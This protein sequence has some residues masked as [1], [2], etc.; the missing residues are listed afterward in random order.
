MEICEIQTRIYECLERN[1]IVVLEDGMLDEFDSVMFITTVVDIESIFSISIPDEYLRIEE[2][3]FLKDIVQI[4]D[5][6]LHNN[7]NPLDS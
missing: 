4:V 7:E 5:I 1:G 6:V 3:K 2:F